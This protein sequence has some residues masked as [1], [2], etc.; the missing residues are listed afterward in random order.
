M[1]VAYSL[2][3]PRA[4]LFG[5]VCDDAQHE[6]YIMQRIWSLG[7]LSER[8]KYALAC[9]FSGSRWPLLFDEAV[10][11]P[12]FPL[13]AGPCSAEGRQLLADPAAAFV[14]GGA[15]H[16]R[17]DAYRARGGKLHT[18]AY[19]PRPIPAGAVGNEYTFY[20]LERT[21]TFLEMGSA[22]FPD[23]D[24][25]VAAGGWEAVDA[26]L[27]RTKWVGPTLGKMF[28]VSTHL[29]L[30]RLQLLRG[31][32]E[33]GVGA[34]E[35]FKVLWPGLQAAADY[36][37]LPDRRAVLAKLF[38]HVAS[39]AAAAREPRLGG[40]AAWCARAAAAKYAAQGF[41]AEAFTRRLNLLE[42]QVNLCEWRKFRCGCVHTCPN[43]A[44]L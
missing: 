12:C 44:S 1:G 29:C 36:G 8:D 37:P 32:V 33:V 22:L 28:L 15:V 10:M 30:P 4:R 14:R 16:R 26:A 43:A 38:A 35:A 11:D 13:G 3:P 31:G 25:L 39:D 19:S 9:G 27:Q 20:I 5:F 23:L 18:L 17:F 2:P 42:F 21:R 34:Q 7:Y 41:P 6:R 24:A 40:M